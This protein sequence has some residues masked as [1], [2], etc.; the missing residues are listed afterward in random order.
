MPS[1]IDPAVPVAGTPTTQ[2]VRDNFAAAK[3]EIEALQLISAQL[4]A[5]FTITTSRADGTETI[6][7][8]T[9]A[10]DAPSAANPIRIGFY[11]DLGAFT[12]LTL[13]AAP[14]ITLSSGSTL[15]AEDGAYIDLW[16]LAFND[17]GTFRLGII[18]CDA[19]DGV[20]ELQDNTVYTTTAEGGAGG[21][22]DAGVIYADTHMS[23]KPARVLG[24]LSYPIVTAGTWDTA[25]DFVRTFSPSTPLP[26]PDPGPPPS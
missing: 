5:G 23:W 8:A 24:V 1:A 18:N 10:G 4:L 25:P 19:P 16:L 26:R 2:S 21:A 11:D 12:A 22:D 13:T 14:T 20:F 7:L 3:S 17:S 15:G 9:L 6:A